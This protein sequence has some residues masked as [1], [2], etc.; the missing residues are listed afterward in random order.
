MKTI[1]L[2]IPG[3]I[4]SLLFYGCG[5]GGATAAANLLP[6]AVIDRLIATDFDA[7]THRAVQVEVT[8]EATS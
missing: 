2:S 5:A 3:L 6:Q 1:F 8:G 4:F 7:E